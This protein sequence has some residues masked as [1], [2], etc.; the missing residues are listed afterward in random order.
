MSDDITTIPVQSLE[1]GLI[2]CPVKPRSIWK[3]YKGA[4]VEVLTLAYLESDLT[5]CVVYREHGSGVTWIRTLA[6]WEQMVEVD[7]KA[8]P[9]F[10]R[11]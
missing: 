7:G 10:R 5:L 4:V 11:F 8:V 2:H 1:D 9:R 6:E 3:H